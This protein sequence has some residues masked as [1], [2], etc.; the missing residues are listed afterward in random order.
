MQER[1]NADKAVPVHKTMDCNS[2]SIS[3]WILNLNEAIVNAQNI[4]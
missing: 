4:F 2:C 3:L 1:T